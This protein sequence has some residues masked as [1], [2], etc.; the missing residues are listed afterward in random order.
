MITKKEKREYVCSS[1]GASYPSMR[2]QCVCKK[3]NTIEEK[4]VAP[5][6]YRLPKVSI[7]MKEAM[8]SVDPQKEALD[9]WF[10]MQRALAMSGDMKCQE[11]GVSI[12]NDLNSKDTWIWRRVLSHIIPKSKF[13]STATHPLNCLFLCW[14]C[15]SRFDNTWDKA[16]KMKIWTLAIAKAKKT[17]PLIKESSS[18]LPSEFLEDVYV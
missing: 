10:D 16:R 5:K 11:C 8:K 12:A 2:G 9:A 17:L 7:K 3:W 13:S 15:H 6:V 4:T 18:S 14:D 1:C